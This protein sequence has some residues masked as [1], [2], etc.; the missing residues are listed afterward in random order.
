MNKTS[1]DS[2]SPIENNGIKSDVLGSFSVHICCGDCG[3]E[4]NSTVEMTAEEIRKDWTRL[5]MSSG[6]N[7]GKCP[8]GC[9]STFSDLNINTDLKLYDCAAKKYID[10]ERFL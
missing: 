8:N 5:V 3:T 4:M 1:N 10:K 2:Q 7:A 6:F 9:R